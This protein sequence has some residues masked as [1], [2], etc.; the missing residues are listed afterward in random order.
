MVC[1]KGLSTNRN[2]QAK[3]VLALVEIGVGL[4]ECRLEDE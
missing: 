3:E 1:L 4:F 2:E